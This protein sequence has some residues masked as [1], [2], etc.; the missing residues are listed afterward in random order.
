[1]GIHGMDIHGYPWVSMDIHRYP[2]MCIDI[3]GYSKWLSVKFGKHLLIPA[4]PNSQLAG[5]I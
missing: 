3:H 5:Y 1:M 4:S 2:W